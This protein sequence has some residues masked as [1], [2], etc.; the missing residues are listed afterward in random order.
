[1]TQKSP[2]RDAIVRLLRELGPMSAAE[3]GEI[4]GKPTGT[5]HS[6][7]ADARKPGNR[8]FYIAGYGEAVGRQYR[9]PALFANGNKP[10]VDYPHLGMA[11]KYKRHWQR[12]K[13]RRRI[14]AVGPTNPFATLIA[15]V[16]Q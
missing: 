14:S 16:S 13:M 8:R 12:E 5:I 3:L 10:D 6:C 11:Q 1:M 15:Q 9:R 2:T 7:I 4:L